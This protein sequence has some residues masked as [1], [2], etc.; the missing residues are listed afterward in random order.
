MTTGELIAIKKK[1]KGINLELLKTT[2]KKLKALGKVNK[3]NRAEPLTENEVKIL[4]EK[5]IIGIHDPQALINKLWLNNTKL[6]GL[7]GLNEYHK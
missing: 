3:P 4:H 6:F 2:K 5:G 7:R 1:K